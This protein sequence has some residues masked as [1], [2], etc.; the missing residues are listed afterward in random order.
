MNRN[1]LIAL[2]ES[3]TKKRE[4]KYVVCYPYDEFL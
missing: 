1:E 4:R 2:K 3:L